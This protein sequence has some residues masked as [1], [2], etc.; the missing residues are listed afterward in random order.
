MVLNNNIGFIV[1]NK[2]YKKFRGTRRTSVL[3]EYI[4]TTKLCYSQHY[5]ISTVHLRLVT[6]FI[7]YRAVGPLLF[8]KPIFHCV[9]QKYPLAKWTWSS[10]RHKQVNN[11]VGFHCYSL[12][13]KTKLSVHMKLHTSYIYDLIQFCLNFPSEANR[14]GLNDE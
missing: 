6:T 13:G 1:N 14:C 10:W 2:Y 12:I 4:T 11:A 7:K 8:T 5:S 3:Y 9:W